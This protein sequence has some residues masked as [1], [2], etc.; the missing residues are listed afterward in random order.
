MPAAKPIS[1]D[2]CLA[3][4]NKTKS[5]KAAARYLNCSYHHLKRYMKLYVDEET[6]QTLFDKHKNQ[7]GKGIPKFLKSSGKDPALIDIV[8]GR[9]DPSSFSPEKIKYRLL[10]EGFFR[11]V[12]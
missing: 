4:M 6:N 7:S 2:M 9:I 3:A 11:R 1:K 10:A 12:L 5:V 8:E